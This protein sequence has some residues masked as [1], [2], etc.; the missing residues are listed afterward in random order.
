MT[1]YER[2]AWVKFKI[3][4]L[5]RDAWAS[6]LGSGVAGYCFGVVWANFV[7]KPWMAGWGDGTSG[8]ARSVTGL[9]TGYWLFGSDG[10]PV[11]LGLQVAV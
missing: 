2:K 11:W 1:D 6:I 8:D 4:F 5:A 10:E 3:A 9:V 7:E